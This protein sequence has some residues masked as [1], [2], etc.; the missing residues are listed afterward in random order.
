MKRFCDKYKNV[1]CASQLHFRKNQ[2]FEAQEAP[3]PEFSASRHSLR[4]FNGCISLD[5]IKKAVALAQGAPSAC[6]RQHV[7]VHC[8]STHSLRDKFL[9][10]QNGCR[11][12]GTNADKVLVVTAD[13]AC[14]AWPEERNDGFTNAGIFLMNLCYSL[15]YYGIGHCILNWSVSPSIDKVIRT[16]LPIENS[17]NIAAVVLC[18]KPTNEFDVAA[19]PRKCVDDIF[20]VHE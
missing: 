12:F 9:E 1:P 3:F 14:I 18:G 19:S 6:N 16:I 17:E 11:G 5:V 13:L 10:F 7:R 8:I 15:H 4:H 20:V 2:F